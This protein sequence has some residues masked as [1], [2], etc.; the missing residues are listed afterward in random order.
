MRAIIPTLL[1]II[2]FHLF[3][4][5]ALG[6]SQQGRGNYNEAV[7]FIKKKQYDFA[8]MS[9]RSIARNFPDSMYAADSLFG[10]G[11]Y[12]YNQGNNS[13][14]SKYFSEYVKLYPESEGAIFARAYLLKIIKNDE[15][16]SEKLEME[17]FSEPLFLLFSEYK[18][19]SYKSAFQNDFSI[20]YY[21]DM[22]EV[23]RN[24][25]LFIKITK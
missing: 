16:V 21:I 10:I 20:R 19:F 5:S 8:L 1:F 25:D 7:R 15:D 17:F 12:F 18:E 11:E 2:S 24:D 4:S 13:E 14:A 23:Y 6:L 22:I 3:C 9:F